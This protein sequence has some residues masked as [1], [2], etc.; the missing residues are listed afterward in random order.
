[1]MADG[2]RLSVAVPPEH[3]R[4]KPGTGAGRV[5]HSV[6]PRLRAL[7]RVEVAGRIR[8]RRPDVWL[9]P[10]HGRPV[11]RR[12]PVVAVIHGSA[13]MLDAST[14]DLIPREFAEPFVA[15][16][17]R[18]L[19]RAGLAIVP[20]DYTRRGLTEGLGIPGERVVVVPHGV[21]PSVFNPSRRG[22]RRL[23]RDALGA[24]TPYVLFA[25]IPSIRQKNLSALKTAMTRLAANGFPHALAIA[26]GT[27]GGEPPE[28]LEEIA[29]DL[30][31]F[32]GRVAWL[33]HLADAELA[34]LM[35]EADAFCLPSLFEAFGLTAL[36][37]LACGAPVVVS[38]RGALPEVVGGAALLAEP[39]PDSLEAEL[40]RLLTD[41]GLAGRLR[42]VGPERA[43][44][45][46]WERT[47]EGWFQALERAAETH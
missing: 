20:S 24:D 36:E 8:L 43:A 21:E 15:N 29:A 27:A 16:T 31:G 45:M 32:P 47:A 41:D 4:V 12:E 26:G 38:N 28:L 3:F 39:S 37:A 35:A 25:S 34:A 1:M 17:E 46:T 33:G 22:G 13:W 19:E 5:W 6:L 10:A 11:E 30:P 44:S 18:T 9:L 2:P 23:V 42:A 40:V 14:L 7:A